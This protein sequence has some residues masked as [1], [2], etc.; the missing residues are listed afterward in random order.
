MDNSV[1]DGESCARGVEIRRSLLE[2][3]PHDVLH[4][5]V[6]HALARGGLG[7]R[8]LQLVELEE[9]ELAVAAELVDVTEVELQDLR[10]Q[11]VIEL[12]ARKHLLRGV[13]V[14]PA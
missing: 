5:N 10:E 14:V 3:E 12:A 11:R 1:D 4:G 13:R 2:D 8:R 6:E 7:E 9:H